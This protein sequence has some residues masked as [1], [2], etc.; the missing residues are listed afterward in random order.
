[1]KMADIGVLRPR[2]EADVTTRLL[3]ASALLA[4]MVV[5]TSAQD[6]RTVLQAVAGN[7]GADNLTTL[8]ISGTAGSSAPGA[9][10]S[11]SDDWPRFELT[12]YTKQID[13]GVRFLREQMTRQWGRYPQLGGGQGVMGEDTCVSV[14]RG[15]GLGPC[16]RYAELA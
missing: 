9:S 16:C 8:Q 12:S 6:A 10:Y 1:M 11:P 2:K 4:L 5:G 14:R 13:S 7:I 15:S 3:T